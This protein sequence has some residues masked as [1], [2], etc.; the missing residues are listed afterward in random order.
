[1]SDQEVF[2]KIHS[3]SHS[4]QIVNGWFEQ[5]W[6]NWNPDTQNLHPVTPAAWEKAIKYNG[7]LPEVLQNDEII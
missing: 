2:T 3:W 4:H 1:M 6:K 7:T 5:K